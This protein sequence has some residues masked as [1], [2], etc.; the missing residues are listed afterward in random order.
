VLDYYR[1]NPEAAGNLRAPIFEEKVVDYIVELA[2]PAERKVSPQEL[3][4]MTE[5][6]E[7]EGEAEASAAEEKPAEK[8]PRRQTGA[9]RAKAEAKGEP[10]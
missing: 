7:G 5:A 10:E 9:R 3:L 4:A 8:K 6:D 2:K 1:N